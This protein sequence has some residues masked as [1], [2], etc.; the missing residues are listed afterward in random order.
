[1]CFLRSSC[2]LRGLLES[3]SSEYRNNVNFLGRQYVN[4]INI[5]KIYKRVGEEIISVI[6]VSCFLPAGG[7]KLVHSTEGSSD[8]KLQEP[9]KLNKDAE[10]VMN[11]R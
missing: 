2:F 9:T 6:H 1:V 7:R 4:I 8:W 10:T 11:N 3:I 5:Y